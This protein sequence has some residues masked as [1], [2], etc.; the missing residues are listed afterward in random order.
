MVVVVVGA[1]SGIGRAAALAFAGHGCRLVLAAR[2][3][4]ALHEVERAIAARGGQALVVPT[5]ITYAESV[6]R[7][8]R[9]AVDHLGRIDVWVEAAAVLLAGPFGTEPVEEIRR[10]IDTNVLGTV[11]GARTDLDTFR[12]QGHGGSSSWDPCSGW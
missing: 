10:L 3:E 9:Q 4:E 2:S 1:S 8:G 12:A 6:E 5:D 11:L 7:L